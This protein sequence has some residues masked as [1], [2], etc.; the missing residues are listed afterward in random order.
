M[1]ALGHVAYEI[2]IEAVAVAPPQFTRT[3][4][5]PGFV[6]VEITHDQVADPDAF[7]VFVPSPAAVLALPAGVV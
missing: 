2:T 6:P 3:V 1:T 5:V 7:A 4:P